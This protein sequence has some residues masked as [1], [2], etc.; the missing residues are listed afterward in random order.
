MA[1]TKKVGSAGRFGSRY[2]RR[3]RQRVIDIEKKQKKKQKCPYC[4]AINVKRISTGIYKCNKCKSKFTGK[5]YF[6]K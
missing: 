6:L 1:R 3:I 2:G 4:N 5:A